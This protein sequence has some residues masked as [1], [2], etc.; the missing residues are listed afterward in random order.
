MLQQRR[1]TKHTIVV[2]IDGRLMVEFCRQ[3]A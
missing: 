1:S 2:N 3:N